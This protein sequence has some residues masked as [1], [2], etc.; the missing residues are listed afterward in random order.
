MKLNSKLFNKALKKNDFFSIYKFKF[1]NLNQFN[2]I[3]N[4]Y[5]KS[6]NNFKFIYSRIKF[7]SKVIEMVEKTDTNVEVDK[8][9]NVENKDKEKDEKSKNRF[10]VWEGILKN[11]EKGKVVTRFPPEPS[12]YLHI[13]HLKACLLNRHYADIYDGQMLVRFDDTNPETE[14]IEF[15]ENIIQDLKIAKMNYSGDIQYVT[16]YFEMLEEIMTTCIAKGLCYCDN[17]PVE[18]SREQRDKGIPSKC[19][20]QSPEENMAIWKQMIDKNIAPDSKIKEYCVRGKIDYKCKNKCMRD[21][22]FYRFVDKPHHRLGD[23]YKLYP[24][25]DFAIPIVDHKGGV[26]HMMRSNEYADR[27]P[28]Y[29]WVE[30]SVGLPEMNIYEYSRLNMSHTLLSKR[31]L[32]WL[33]ENKCVDG[34]D[35]PRLPTIRG[36]IR[37]GIRIES[38]KDFIL[39]I[40]PSTNSNLMSWDKLFAINKDFIDPTSKRLFGVTSENP[41]EVTI[42][43]FKEIYNT[44]EVVEKKDWHPKNKE[45]GQRNQYKFSKLYME[46]EDCKDLIPEMKLTLYSWGNTRIESVNKDEQGNVTHVNLRLTLDDQDF[47]KTKIAHWISAHPDHVIF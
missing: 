7:H 3:R 30:Q 23:K 33:V 24:M 47:K 28:M 31:K 45:L 44:D 36:I 2:L 29:R 16:D 9:K 37:R 15:V 42:S 26:T 25:Y 41:T 21:P 4:H 22:T 1:S 34:W 35:D 10:V 14:S 5:F 46:P 20:D 39:E 13:G 6:Q 17:T 18:I 32:K 8:L 19:R 12:G 40:G 27:I 11:A 38:L 43:N